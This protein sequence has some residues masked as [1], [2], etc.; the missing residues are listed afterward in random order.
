MSTPEPGL[1]L[2][3]WQT[4]MALLNEQLEDSPL[5]ALPEL[6]DLVERIMVERRIIDEAGEPVTEQIL[7]PEVIDRYR[8]AREIATLAE[9]GDADPGDLADAINNLRELFDGLV[10]EHGAP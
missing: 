9:A 6:A 3:D 7:D 2:H 8:S 4:Q 1:D 5:E 10:V